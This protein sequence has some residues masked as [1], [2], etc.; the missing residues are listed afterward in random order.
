[1][2][3]SFIPWYCDPRFLGSVFQA[4]GVVGEDGAEVVNS[5]SLVLVYQVLL[6]VVLSR[7]VQSGNQ[8]NTRAHGSPLAP[9]FLIKYNCINKALFTSNITEGFT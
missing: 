5:L 4:R 1:M 7:A 6:K 9:P 8:K 2:K 3:I